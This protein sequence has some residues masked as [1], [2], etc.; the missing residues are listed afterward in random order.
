MESNQI[1]FNYFY[2]LFTQKLNQ[3]MLEIKNKRIY[4]NN[5]EVDMFDL[6]F[7]PITKEEKLTIYNEALFDICS[8][9]V[10]LSGSCIDVYPKNILEFVDLILNTIHENP[11]KE[12]FLFSLQFI[13]QAYFECLEVGYPTLMYSADD[14]SIPYLKVTLDS[15]YQ[16]MD[17][18]AVNLDTLEQNK[19]VTKFLMME[20]NNQIGPIPQIVYHLRKDI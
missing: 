6:L 4:E 18:D 7:T 14:N 17:F 3:K 9:Y 11:Y 10:T 5:D 2:Q 13:Y 19:L 15:R 1:I 8:D 16:I 20:M 12:S